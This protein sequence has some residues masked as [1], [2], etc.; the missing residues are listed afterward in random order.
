MG[1]FLLLEKY[2]KFVEHICSEVLEYFSLVARDRV[3]NQFFLGTSSV[4]FSCNIREK[5]TQKN[6]FFLEKVFS[7][8]I[9]SPHNFTSE[10]SVPFGSY[11]CIDLDSLPT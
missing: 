8:N 6:L 10:E 11:M 9:L 1:F 2:C 4:F 7:W 3:P 5:K